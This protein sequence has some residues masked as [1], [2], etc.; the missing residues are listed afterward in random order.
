M[1]M[2]GWFLSRSTVRRMRSTQ[3]VAQRGSSLGLPRQ[4][5]LEE[6]VRLEVA[7]VDHP[8]PELVA[9]LEEARVRRVVAGAHGVDVVRASS[10]ARRAH[11]LLGHRAAAVGVELVPVDAAEQHPAGR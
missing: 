9:Q 6:A 2:L 7:L 11:R 8:Q 3:R 4:L 1:T 5:D 10:A